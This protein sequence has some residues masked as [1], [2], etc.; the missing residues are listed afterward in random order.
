MIRCLGMKNIVLIIVGVVLATTGTLKAQNLTISGELP[1]EAL[2]TLDMKPGLM[3]VDLAA[4]FRQEYAGRE[5]PAIIRLD[6]MYDCKGL[7]VVT[8]HMPNGHAFGEK[9]GE[10]VK[11]LIEKYLLQPG[12]VIQ[13]ATIGAW[14]VLRT[15]NTVVQGGAPATFSGSLHEFQLEEHQHPDLG[16]IFFFNGPNGKAM[17]QNSLSQ[18]QKAAP[19]GTQVKLVPDGFAGAGLVYAQ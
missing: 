18:C 9:H 5:I 14:Y 2:E 17:G 11:A 19:N 4:K 6:G 10:K 15:E 7:P 8:F 12:E 3:K 16:K 13:I 1:T